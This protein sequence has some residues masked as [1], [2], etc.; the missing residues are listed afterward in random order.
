MPD[1]AYV[2]SNDVNTLPPIE[3]VA[4]GEPTFVDA[5]ER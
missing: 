5:R 4:L 2:L 3:G 1:V